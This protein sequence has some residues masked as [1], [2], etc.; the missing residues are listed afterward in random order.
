MPSKI[1]ITSLIVIITASTLLWQCPNDL[2]KPTDPDTTSHDFVWEIDTLGEYPSILMDVAVIDEN[3]ILAVGDIKTDSGRFNAARWDDNKWTIFNIETEYMGSMT[4]PPLY[5]ICYFSENDIWANSS[6]PQHWDGNEWTLYHLDDMGLD[7]GIIYSVLGTSSSNIYFVGGR[8]TIIHY[9]GQD[10]TKFNT[11][12][13]LRLL[14]VYGNSSRQEPE[15]WA[16]GHSNGSQSIVLEYTGNSF[17]TKFLSEDYLPE[18][19]TNNFGRFYSVWSYG[20]T[21]YISCVG[22][23]WKESLK[24]GKGRLIS[25]VTLGTDHNDIR[26]MRGNAYNDIMMISIYGEFFHY[27]GKSWFKDN[28]LYLQYPKGEMITK[29]MDYQDDI[30]VVVGYYQGGNHALVIRGHHIDN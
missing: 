6:Y 14:D 23:L 12:T 9:D 11:G 18:G 30:C 19:C 24:T 16:C 5:S 1:P 22:G 2:V 27:N 7:A 26:K 8:G 21:L 17:T 10:F 28:T 29:S 4:D 3:T 25:A 15:V 20:D 13:E